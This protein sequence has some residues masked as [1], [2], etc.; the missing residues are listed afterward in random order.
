MSKHLFFLR[1]AAL[2][3]ATAL[4][5]ALATTAQQTQ[6]LGRETAL[7]DGATQADG[8]SVF[9]LTLKLVARPRGQR[10]RATW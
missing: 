8:S 10:D 2:P 7:L 4:V 5:V 1:P 9:A 6:L 3:W